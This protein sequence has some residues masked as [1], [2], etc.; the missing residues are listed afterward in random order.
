MD[1]N[2]FSSGGATPSGA[3]SRD[4]TGTPGYGNTGDVSGAQGYGAGTT[5][6]VGQGY[7]NSSTEQP[8]GLADRAREVAGTAQDKLADVGSTVRDRAGQMK[9]SLA[10]VLHSGADKLR[11][12]STAPTG[13]SPQLAGATD[14]GSAAVSVDNRTARVTNRVAGGMDAAADWLRDADLDGLKAGLERQVKENP[15]RTLLVAAGLGYLLGKAFR[16]D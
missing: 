16:R 6:D 13:S 5:A 4:F 8:S 12:R 9:N 11:D 15:G 3:G 14:T 7:P 1:R 10:D 2:D